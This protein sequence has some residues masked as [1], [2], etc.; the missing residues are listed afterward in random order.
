MAIAEN[1]QR[2]AE[3]AHER[4]ERSGAGDLPDWTYS[5]PRTILKKV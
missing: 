3:V 1:K 2:D 5:L 4:A